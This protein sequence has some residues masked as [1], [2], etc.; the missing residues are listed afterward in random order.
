MFV[1]LPFMLT[2]LIISWV[3][4]TV[5]ATI[6]PGTWIGDL[7]TSGGAAIVGQKRGLIAFLIGACIALASLWLLGLIVRIEARRAL[8]RT[9]D[10]VLA[11]VPLF[12][13][14]YRPVSQVVRLFAASKAD[15]AG[16][17]VVMCRLGGDQGADVP[18]LLAANE[19]FDVG[20]DRRLLVYLPTSPLPAW[21]GLV[22]VPEAA[23]IRVPS[24][25]ADALIKLYFSFGV[26]AREV[27][28][29]VARS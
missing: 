7:L 29:T 27:I 22:L 5:G 1:L 12:R 24:M 14:I 20:G 6:G 8:D 9:L 2:V 15:L 4:S 11:T 28:P 23:V 17:P 19:V 25:D 13:S 26:L 18:A 21:G 10:D 16:L 3:I